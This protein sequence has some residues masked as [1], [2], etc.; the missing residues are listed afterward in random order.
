MQIDKIKTRTNNFAMKIFNILALRTSYLPGAADFLAGYRGSKCRLVSKCNT[1]SC[2]IL[3]GR[4][5]WMIISL[6]KK[7]HYLFV[8]QYQVLFNSIS[9]SFKKKILWLKR[10]SAGR[11]AVQLAAWYIST[12]IHLNSST[13]INVGHQF[14]RFYYVMPT[15]L[16]TKYI[17][18]SSTSC[19]YSPYCY[20]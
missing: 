2:L 14:S 17:G 12:Y 7:M 9:Q 6:K 16:S 3:G 4:S 5:Y 19:T 13:Y 10:K 15:N 20:Y 18:M 8:F 11:I 1:P